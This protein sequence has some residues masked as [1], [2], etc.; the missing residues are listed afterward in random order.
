[1]GENII[2]TKHKFMNINKYSLT[3]SS[4]KELDFAKCSTNCLNLEFL[5]DCLLFFHAE[6]V[7]KQKE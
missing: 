1:M 5:L 4:F 7:N 6:N 3:M 2:N